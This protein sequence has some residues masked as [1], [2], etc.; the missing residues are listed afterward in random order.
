MSSILHANQ[1]VYVPSLNESG[2]IVS[3]DDY[4]AVYRVKF[5]EYTDTHCY[6]MCYNTANT[7]KYLDRDQ[8]V[9]V[10]SGYVHLGYSS[11]Y[12]GMRGQVKERRW[13]A[14]AGDFNYLILIPESEF[15]THPMDYLPSDVSLWLRGSQIRG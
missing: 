8:I 1:P 3:R 15:E 7:Y 11:G 5:T 2:V 6:D 13:S 10:F 4:E 9:P 12:D 14:E